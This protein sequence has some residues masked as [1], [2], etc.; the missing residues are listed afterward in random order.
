M[1][2]KLDTLYLKR[3]KIMKNTADTRFYVYAYLDPRKPGKY[4][5]GDYSFDFEPFYIGKGTGYRKNGHLKES[6]LKENSYK[7]NKIKK[8]IKET[9]DVPV[10]LMLQSEITEQ[11]ALS[12]EKKFVALIGRSDLHKGPLTNLTDAGDGPSNYS[13]ETKNKISKSNTGKKASIE[14]KFKLSESRTGEKNP[15]FG[16]KGKDA[17]GYGRKMS[18]EE[19]QHLSNIKKG[20]NVNAGKPILESTRK[21]LGDSTRGKTYEEIY[22]EE[23]AKELKSKRIE[24]NKNR[25]VSQETKNKIAENNA[26]KTYKLTNPNGD[27]I[28]IKNLSKFCKNNNLTAT[29]MFTVAYGKQKQH[30]GWKC[31]LVN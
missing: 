31:E 7:N 26:K 1:V 10:I 27:I 15:M 14:T 28:L 17:P 5:Y 30:K 21:K 12:L 29:L 2:L 8:I 16:R 6:S 13:Q 24:S 19:K 4:V 11:N 25:T 22:G 18:D 3:F 20:I 23:K 9:N